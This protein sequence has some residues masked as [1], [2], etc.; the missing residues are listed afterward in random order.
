MPWND[1]SWRDG[2]DA[3]KLRSPDD[4]YG[5]H[6]DEGPEASNDCEM[7]NGCR[8]I[9]EINSEGLASCVC[10]LEWIPSAEEKAAFL[11]AKADLRRHERR[12]RDREFW[13]RLTYPIRWPIFR[14]LEKVWPRKAMRVLDDSEVPF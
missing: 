14:L 1:D 13:R 2:Y 11:A 7:E 9:W 6:P 5:W 8:V 10:G 3:W 4:D 12:E